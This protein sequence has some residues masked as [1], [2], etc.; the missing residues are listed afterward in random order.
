[1]AKTSGNLV[2]AKLISQ[3]GVP[4]IEFMFNPNELTF[5]RVAKITENPGARTE[6]EGLP[7][8]SF[9]H[10]TAYEV[11]INQ[12][13][14]DTYEEGKNVVTKYI[15]PFQKALKFVSGKERTPIYMFSWGDQ[16]YLRRCFIE[17]LTYKLTMFLPNGTPVRAVIDNL[18]LK[19][20]DKPQP[21]SS[22]EAKNPS[23]QQRQQTSIP[24]QVNKKR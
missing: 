22:V 18:T 7:K 24:S 8:V 5:N 3:D 4:P 14:F 23:S 10:I 13:M 21:S 17:S 20:A 16:V 11:S 19:E 9:S 2:K 15:E 6:D 12:I 1:M